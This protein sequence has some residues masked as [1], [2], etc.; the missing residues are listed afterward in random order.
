V[1]EFYSER[2]TIIADVAGL[3]GMGLAGFAAST[4]VWEALATGFRTGRLERAFFIFLV[5]VLGAS[6]V[7]GVI[8]LWTGRVIG[9]IWE[10]RHRRLRPPSREDDPVAVVTAA[11]HGA[12]AEAAGPATSAA[13]GIA[14]R[15]FTSDVAAPFHELMRRVSR[16]PNAAETS[17]DSLRRSLNIGAWD[18]GRLV[19]VVRVMHDGHASVVADLVVDP[20]YRRRGIARALIQA[21]IAGAPGG[22]LHVIAADDSALPFLRA[23]GARAEPRAFRLS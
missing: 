23:L 19:G 2:R 7:G 11:D 13:P 14:L 22:V 21:A 16:D 5:V 10:R 18:A 9:G 8:G 17:A 20:D 6:A 3:L 15:G 12:T 1:S 4:F